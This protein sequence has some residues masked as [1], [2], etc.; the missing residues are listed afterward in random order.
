MSDAQQ[1]DPRLAGERLAHLAL[2]PRERERGAVVVDLVA[3][4][5]LEMGRGDLAVYYARVRPHGAEGPTYGRLLLASECDGRVAYTL[6]VRTEHTERLI[7]ALDVG[8]RRLRDEG[9][10]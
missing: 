3:L 4:D 7:A 2:S 5:R 1:I 10:T 9:G 8:A 6:R